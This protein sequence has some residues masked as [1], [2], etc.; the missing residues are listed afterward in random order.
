MGV[1]DFSLSERVALLTG[2]GRGI[3]LGIAQ[4][5]AASGCAVAIQDIDRD[6]AE[7]EAEKIRKTGCRAIALDG[8]VHNIDAVPEWV[9]HVVAKLGGIH[10][11]VNNAAV[12][13]QRS[14]LEWSPAEME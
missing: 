8:D 6:V 1:P 3:G 9:D 4:A 5:F 11:L 14:F 7:A 2:A 13:S 10:I 12:Q